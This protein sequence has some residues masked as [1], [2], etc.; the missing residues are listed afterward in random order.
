ML[1]RQVEA[2]GPEPVKKCSDI[3]LL[4]A[5]DA[6]GHRA[7]CIL[8]TPQI[9]QHTQHAV[10]GVCYAVADFATKMGQ[11]DVSRS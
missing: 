3:A 1:R 6:C 8:G 10:H 11:D 7:H 9:A 5:K 2:G 4:G